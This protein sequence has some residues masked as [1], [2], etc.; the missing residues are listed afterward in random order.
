MDG[1]IHELGLLPVFE[2]VDVLYQKSR[3]DHADR[4]GREHRHIFEEGGRRSPI[5]LTGVVIGRFQ[6]LR[7]GRS[8]FWKKS[9]HPVAR[10][11]AKCALNWEGITRY[12]KG[13]GRV[14]AGEG[15]VAFLDKS[16]LDQWSGCV[17]ATGMRDVVALLVKPGDGVL[18][19]RISPGEIIGDLA[20]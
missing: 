6:I 20:R 3:Q 10:R 5:E 12:R 7:S 9:I 13:K 4:S 19:D 1:L 14:G 8:V 16:A 15:V 2:R 11:Q 18:D 17:D